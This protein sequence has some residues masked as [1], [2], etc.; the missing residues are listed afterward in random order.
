MKCSLSQRLTAGLFAALA[1]T[2]FPLAPAMAQGTWKAERPIRLLV[3]FVPGGSADAFA[4]MIADPLGHRL[5]QSVVV[6]NI[7][8]AGGNIMAARLAAAAPD[9]YTIGVGSA[10]ALSITYELNPK[11]TPYRPESFTPITMLTTQPNVVLVNNTVP[12]KNL[13]E[14]KSFIQKTPSA[15]YGIAGIGVS[16]HL[17]T[18]AML[19]GMGLTMQSVSYKGGSQMITDLL[20]G[21]IQLAMDNITS[22]S[23]LAK[24][25][26]A[27]PIAVT[28]IKRSSQLPDVPTLAEQGLGGFDMV[29]WQGVFAPAGLPP[30]ILGSY[31]D[32]LQEIARTPA[33]REKM[34]LLGLDVVTGMKPVD[35]TAYIDK[36]RKTWGAIIKAANI[37]P[38]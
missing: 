27:R 36:D 25:G 34:Q 38:E 28:T 33:I 21:H 23:Q 6:E 22:A 14:L 3:G 10:G 26:R 18:E 13:G 11:A 9:G 16:N 29:T 4:R 1:A 20:G 37:K 12:A 8:G 17:M 2:L 7:P 15:S 30:H 24:D 19:R 31:Y 35:F 32:A 5:G